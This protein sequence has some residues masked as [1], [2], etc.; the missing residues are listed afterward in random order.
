MDTPKKLI[1]VFSTN[2]QEQLAFVKSLLSSAGIE[3]TTRNENLNLICGAAD[4]FTLMDVMVPE[5][6][7]E[8]ARELLKN[9]DGGKR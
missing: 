3:F 6:E 2:R 8:A 1:R 5:E 7:A 9:L 4:G